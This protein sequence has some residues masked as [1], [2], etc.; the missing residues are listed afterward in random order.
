M[1]NLL[2]KGVCGLGNRMLALTVAGELCI[3]HRIDMKVCWRDKMYS[4]DGS[5]A[6]DRFFGIKGKYRANKLNGSIFPT[7][8]RGNIDVP[9][10]ELAN[11]RGK[12]R[13]NP[14]YKMVGISNTHDTSVIAPMCPDY[15]SPKAILQLRKKLR[16]FMFIKADA[17]ALI[18]MFTKEKFIGAEHIIGVH[19]RWAAPTKR[20]VSLD[21]LVN[22]ID[23]QIERHPS[24]KVMIC[25]D[26]KEPINILGNIY[27]DRLILMPKWLPSGEVTNGTEK[28]ALHQPTSRQDKTNQSKV[29]EEAVKEMGCLAACDTIIYQHN[30]SFGACAAVLSNAGSSNIIPW[31]EETNDTNENYG[32]HNSK[33]TKK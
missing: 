7:N 21:D 1:K 19:V 5:N 16:R 26:N 8:W 14:D 3:K 20:K 22:K 23:R 24:S 30:S 29:Y 25:A 28:Q 6:F 9:F 33:K 18:A 12:S 13:T 15:R 32:W 11:F 27:A 10:D 4:D 2:V 31:G 17:M